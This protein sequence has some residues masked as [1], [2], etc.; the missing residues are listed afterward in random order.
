MYN[1]PMLKPDAL[2]GKTILVTG[3]GTGLGKSMSRYFSQLGA[4]IVI[5]SRKMDVLSAT[6]DELSRETGG[7]VLPLAC[8][9]RNY[10]EV[11][12]VLA[13]ATDAFGKAQ[14]NAY[15]TKRLT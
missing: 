2:K 1:E 13:A 7:R 15:R 5:T 4:N 6:A 9:V 12:N 11:E 10:P 14:P 3:G 8:D